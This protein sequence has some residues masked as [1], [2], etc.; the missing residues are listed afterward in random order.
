VIPY[1]T[2]SLPTLD[3]EKKITIGEKVRKRKQQGKEK[4]RLFRGFFNEKE[5]LSKE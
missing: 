4:T 2:T 1:A 3:E 5:K